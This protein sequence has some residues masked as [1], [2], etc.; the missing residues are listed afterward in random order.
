MARRCQGED[1]RVCSLCLYNP[2]ILKE[3]SHGVVRSEKAAGPTKL[4]ESSI[5]RMAPPFI[6]F[7]LPCRYSSVAGLKVDFYGVPQI[8]YHG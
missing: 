8:L 4:P 3:L 2:F 7:P 6:D 5:G 1:N